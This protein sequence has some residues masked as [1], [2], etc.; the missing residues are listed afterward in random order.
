MNSIDRLYDKLADP[1]WARW[2]FILAVII[3][4]HNTLTNLSFYPDKFE[5]IHAAYNYIEGQGLSRSILNLETD[6]VENRTLIQFPPGYPILLIGLQYITQDLVMAVLFLDVICLWVFIF[7]LRFYLNSLSLDLRVISAIWLLYIIS[8]PVMNVLTNPGIM[9]LGA[10]LCFLVFEKKAGINAGLVSIICGALAYFCHYSYLAPIVLVPLFNGGLSLVKEKKINPMSFIIPVV[11][12]FG[13]YIHG[14][15]NESM[16]GYR[17]YSALFEKSEHFQ[18]VNL[19]QTTFYPLNLLF[20]PYH[21]IFQRLDLWCAGYLRLVLAIPFYAGIVYWLVA[22]YRH[23]MTGENYKRYYQVIATNVAILGILAYLTISYPPQNIVGWKSNWSYVWEDRYYAPAGIILL[24]LLLSKY[25]V[26]RKFI[27]IL[28]MFAVSGYTFVDR[29]YGYVKYN[30]S[31]SVLVSSPFHAATIQEMKAL[32]K[33]VKSTSKKSVFISR[34]H[35]TG[36][37]RLTGIYLATPIEKEYIDFTHYDI[38]VS[39]SSLSEYKFDRNRYQIVKISQ[40][41]YNIKKI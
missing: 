28:L 31:V 27:L 16:T 1:K 22:S 26:K 10:F 17:S 15:I 20:K 2:L 21:P 4:T 13:Y 36:L 29:V 40:N 6:K 34:K 9:G 37:A 38:Y 35:N 12:V 8:N 39:E 32:K 3:Q 33:A 7:S 11:F 18:W 14:N 30:K 5:Q 19:L 25:V 23:I 41:I 24:I